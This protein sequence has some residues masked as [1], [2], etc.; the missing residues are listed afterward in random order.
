MKH[1]RKVRESNHSGDSD[2]RNENCKNRSER[3]SFFYLAGLRSPYSLWMIHGDSAPITLDCC[4]FN[5]ML[6]VDFESML[7][8][9]YCIERNFGVANVSCSRSKEVFG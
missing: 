2:E 5:L 4:I 6:T 3:T 1:A 8:P 7:V 9:S